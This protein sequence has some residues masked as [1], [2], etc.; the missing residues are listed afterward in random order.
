MI[1]PIFGLPGHILE[2]VVQGLAHALSASG[3]KVRIERNNS[4]ESTLEQLILS[5]A[6]DVLLVST[7]PNRQLGA[8]FKRIPCKK[9]GVFNTLLLSVGNLATR[10]QEDINTETRKVVS[11][12]A[13]IYELLLAEETI[14]VRE[15]D[16]AEFEKLLHDLLGRLGYEAARPFVAEAAKA[17]AP[18]ARLIAEDVGKQVVADE[19]EFSYLRLLADGF[20]PLA[21]RRPM[22]RIVVMRE[23]FY[24][25]ADE[26]TVNARVVDATGRPRCLF[27]GPYLALPA[28]WWTLRL[29][30]GFAGELVG[31][32]FM[33]DIAGTDADG[34][35]QIASTE[36]V[37]EN[38]GRREIILPFHV[39]SPTTRL[40]FRLYSQKAVFDG[41]VALGYAELTRSENGDADIERAVE[42]GV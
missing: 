32:P 2:I 39:P 23:F 36:F 10:H 6:D 1:I 8:L 33:A 42:L 31:R 16:V 17:V 15:R 40:E 9:I 3:R 25:M 19:P 7:H 24:M 13:C 11:S 38:A 41:R 14:L 37:V 4:P 27:W 34:I 30:I 20:D 26:R 35:D 12:V 18:T 28:G 21:E 22:S 5:D 29:V